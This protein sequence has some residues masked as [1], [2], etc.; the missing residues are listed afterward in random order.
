MLM[1]QNCSQLYT[2]SATKTSFAAL[3]TPDS[4]MELTQNFMQTH[5]TNKYKKTDPQ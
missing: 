4:E 5:E 3:L 1:H 2:P